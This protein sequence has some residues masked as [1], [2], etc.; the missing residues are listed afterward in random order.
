MHQHQKSNFN[1]ENN[2]SCS[3]DVSIR[4]KSLEFYCEYKRVPR[5]YSQIL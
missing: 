3:F 4:N 2:W 1:N 5:L